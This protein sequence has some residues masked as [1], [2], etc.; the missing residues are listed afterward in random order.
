VIKSF[1]ILVLMVL[2]CG[3]A[4]LSR[5]TRADFDAYV[6]RELETK[7]SNPVARWIAQ[8]R[9]ESYLDSCTLKDRYLWVTVE[10]GG[11]TRYIG[12]F[13]NFWPI[14]GSDSSESRRQDQRVATGR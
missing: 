2:L 14:S 5:P 3:G 9:V 7:T 8:G 6:R 1:I 12:A 11:K 10:Q 4:Y 13:A